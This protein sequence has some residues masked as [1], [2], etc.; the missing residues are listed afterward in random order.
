MFVSIRLLVVLSRKG[1]VVRGLV[2]VSW[3]LIGV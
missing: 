3:L 1:L 2:L